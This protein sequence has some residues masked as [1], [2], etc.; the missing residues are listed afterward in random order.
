MKHIA[1]IT[2]NTKFIG[3]DDDVDGTVFPICS[4]ENDGRFLWTFVLLLVFLLIGDGFPSD[5]FA[6]GSGSMLAI[7]PL[8]NTPLNTRQ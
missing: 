8:L 7:L 5:I 6:R 2:Q 4:E 1:H 3:D